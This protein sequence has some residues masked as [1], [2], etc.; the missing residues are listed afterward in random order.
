MPPHTNALMRT[1]N[2]IAGWMAISVAFFLPLSTSLSNI[3]FIAA[4]L[5]YLCTGDWRNKFQAIWQRRAI[6]SY[7][8]LFIGMLVAISYSTAPTAAAW[9]GLA[10]YDKLLFGA[11]FLPIFLTEKWRR[12]AIHAFLIGIV[13]T[14]CVALLILLDLLSN[15]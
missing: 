10:K 14:L 2:F 6:A 11:L 13:V 3:L 8:L 15:D 9:Q 7:W 12:Y 4:P 1:L 5:L